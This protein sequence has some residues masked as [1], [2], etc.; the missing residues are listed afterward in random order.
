MVEKIIEK[1][2]SLNTD[3]N[4]VISEDFAKELSVL[5]TAIQ[6][7]AK[8]QGRQDALKESEEAMTEDAKE[9]KAEMYEDAKDFKEEMT[10]DA[11]EFKDQIVESINEYI[12]RF[13]NE[14]LE[15]NK[16]DIVDAIEVQKSKNIQEAFESMIENFG[17]A[18]SDEAVNESIEL[19]ELTE[20]YNNTVNENIE[21][22]KQVDLVAK[23]KIIESVAKTIETD[24]EQ[25]RFKTLAEKFTYNSDEEYTENLEILAQNFT[26]IKEQ[27]KNESVSK[28]EAQTLSESVQEQP[29]S[30]KN[31]LDIYSK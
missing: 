27:A 29:S 17:Y 18:I 28:D 3:D 25:E 13:T 2:L 26:V 7:E 20:K 6:E 31:P 9:F 15:S 30:K 14:F 16:E 24:S 21:L 4:V 22:K 1:L 12:E 10:E 8:E 23:G 19:D 11:S 5:L